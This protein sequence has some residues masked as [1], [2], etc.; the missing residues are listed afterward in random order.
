MSNFHHW[1]W[2]E[3]HTRPDKPNY[4]VNLEHGVSIRFDYEKGM[5]ADF[6]EFYAEIAD[7]QFLSGNRPEKEEVKRLLVEAWNYLCEE[8]RILDEEDDF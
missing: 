8:E 3:N 6:E 2:G 4:L 7:V 1:L 5:F